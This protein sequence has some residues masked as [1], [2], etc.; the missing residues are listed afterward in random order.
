ML[1]RARTMEMG[2]A[3]GDKVEVKAT[4]GLT[5]LVEPYHEHEPEPEPAES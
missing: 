2:I 1:W 5:L 4:E 3:E